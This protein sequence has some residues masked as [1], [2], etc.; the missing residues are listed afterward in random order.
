LW[1]PSFDAGAFFEIC[2]H[3]TE[4]LLYRAAVVGK[5]D[6]PAV[7]VQGYDRVDFPAQDLRRYFERLTSLSLPLVPLLNNM[8]GL[9]GAITQLALFGDL[10]SEVRFRWWS[11]PPPT[12]APLV[13]IANEM[14]R[15][16][17]CDVEPYGFS[18]S[19]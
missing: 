10:H 17:G 7:M 8:A 14:L 2:Q 1:L 6:W 16:L 13:A 18:E 15:A 4:W 19:G 3:N 9:D 12:W 5:E 11:E